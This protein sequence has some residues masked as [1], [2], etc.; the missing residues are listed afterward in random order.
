MAARRPGRASRSTKHSNCSA[1]RAMPAASARSR[2]KPATS[3]SIPAMSPARNG[4]SNARSQS[5]P[6]RTTCCTRR[7]CEPRGLARLP[8]RRCR[9][10]RAPRP[11]RALPRRAPFH[12]RIAPASVPRLALVA[13]GDAAGAFTSCERAAQIAQDAG[14]IEGAVR[15]LGNVAGTSG[16][17]APASRRSSCSTARNLIGT[18]RLRSVSAGFNLLQYAR[19]CYRFGYLER[20]RELV[21]QALAMEIDLQKFDVVAAHVGIAVGLL[22]LDDELVERSARREFFELVEG[23]DDSAVP[24]AACAYIDHNVNAAFRLRAR[25]HRRSSTRSTC[26]PTGR[27][28]T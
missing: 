3:R 21:V 4:S 5:P 27:P 14:D 13:A 7:A 9:R 24:Y 26:R 28:T 17:C 18:H 23:L 16:S 10:A 12:R 11:R 6:A 19:T 15:A 22:L 2:W 25:H 20:A 8:R 1:E